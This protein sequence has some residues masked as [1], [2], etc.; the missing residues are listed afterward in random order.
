[1]PEI[2]PVLPA[3]AQAELVKENSELVDEAIKALQKALEIK[4]NDSDAMAYLNLMYR[5]KVDIEPDADARAADLKQAE[6]WVDKAVAR[7]L[8]VSR[9]GDGYC[10][11]SRRAPFLFH[12][13]QPPPVNSLS[14]ENPAVE[15]DGSARASRLSPLPS[16]ASCGGEEDAKSTQAAGARTRRGPSRAK[17]AVCG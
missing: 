17:T 3:K 12:R 8:G 11:D 7:E 6:E 15:E 10:F 14:C 2:L 1:K 9:R 5:E 13:P 16:R 4:P